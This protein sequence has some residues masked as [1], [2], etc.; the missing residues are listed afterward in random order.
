MLGRAQLGVAGD[1]RL[2]ARARAL[3]QL[4]VLG[5]ARDA[6]LPEPGLARADQL[7][8][9]AQ[10]QVDL[11]QAEAVGVRARARAAAPSRRAGRRAGSASGARRDP[12]RPRSWCSWEIPKRSA[13]SISIT[14]ALGTSIPTSITVVATSTS[15]SPEANA[16]IASCFSRGRM[17]P[18]S[19]ASS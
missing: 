15:A 9:L 3:E 14:V 12:T 10:S 17:P 19:S 7:A 8:L 6:E 13:F 2:G 4:R 1:D 5:Q 18:C 11:G 16:A